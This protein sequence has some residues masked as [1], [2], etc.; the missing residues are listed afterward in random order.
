MQDMLLYFDCVNR[1]ERRVL[2]IDLNMVSEMKFLSVLCSGLN[3]TQQVLNDG[4][5]ILVHPVALRTMFNIGTRRQLSV[6]QT[7][8]Q[9]SIGA[10]TD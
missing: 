6:W 8:S 1:I 2:S 3:S 9:Y 5:H 4:N 10:L 7:H